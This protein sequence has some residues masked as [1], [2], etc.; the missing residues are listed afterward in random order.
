MIEILK[1]IKRSISAKNLKTLRGWR[2]IFLTPYLYDII[3][4]TLQ[5]SGIT[6]W[7]NLK[8]FGKVYSK[9]SFKSAVY[10]HN[11]K[12]TNKTLF[13]RNRR[14]EI[15]YKILSLMPRKKDTD[16]KLLIIGPRTVNE[17]YLA[18]CYGY[19]WSCISAIDLFQVH[20]KIQIMDMDDLTFNDESFDEIVISNALAYSENIEKCIHGVARVL[21]PGGKL[22]FQHT[23]AQTVDE[24]NWHIMGVGEVWPGNKVS[25]ENLVKFI[26]QSGLEVLAS[27]PEKYVNSD[28]SDIIKFHVYAAKNI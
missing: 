19:K 12:S 10:E 20:K 15:S 22:V 25:K 24:K 4:I 11:A 14:A 18:W 13:D 1:N 6:R 26:E 23:F 2:R 16:K 8:N 9:D 17:L 21:R 27:I 7:I 5:L 3:T 28:N